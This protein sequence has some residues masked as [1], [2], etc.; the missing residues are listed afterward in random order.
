MKTLQ[1]FIPI[2][3]YC[4]KI[5]DDQGFWEQ[6]EHYISQ[7]SGAQFSHGICPE[8]REQE[9]GHLLGGR[10]PDGVPERKP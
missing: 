4:K 1:G 10:G 6:L 9:F 7:H 5:R 8:C 3:A 2:C